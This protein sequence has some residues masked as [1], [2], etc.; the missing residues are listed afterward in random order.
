MALRE[1]LANFLPQPERPQAAQ[2]RT[3]QQLLQRAEQLEK[4]E[5][6]RQAEAARQ[7]HI[8]EMKTLPAREE[9]SWRKVEDL[10]DNGCKIAAVYDE[11][12]GLLEKL[13]QLSEFQDTR[14]VS[15]QRLRR[16]AEKYSDRSALMSRWHT[17]GWI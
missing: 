6:K 8:T 11:A 13:R 9:Q 4:A 2:P 1:R 5:K 12:T 14:D 3:I 10:L 7:K 16:L 17:K 15:Q